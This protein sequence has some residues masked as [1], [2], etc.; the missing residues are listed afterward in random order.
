MTK[1]SH[2]DDRV[3]KYLN[4]KLA[5]R[6]YNRRP[7]KI[8]YTI[9]KKAVNRDKKEC[10]LS[11]KQIRSSIDR[12][13]ENKIIEKYLRWDENYKRVMYLRLFKPIS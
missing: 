3:M 2:I 8:S 7:L 1:T 10:E 12:L 5:C 4:R 6:K 13:V 11:Y 9:I